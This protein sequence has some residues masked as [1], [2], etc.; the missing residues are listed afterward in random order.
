MKFEGESRVNKL[1]FENRVQTMAQI[2][3]LL[4]MIFK[5]RE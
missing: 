3:E 5:E 4:D 1:M 2:E